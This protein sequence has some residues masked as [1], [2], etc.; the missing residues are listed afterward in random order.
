MGCDIHAHVEIKVKG[1]WLHYSVPSIRRNYDLFA[2]MAN[3]R[4]NEDN[5]I[6][7]LCIP[8]GLPDDISDITKHSAEDWGEDGHDHSWLSSEEMDVV[9]NWMMDKG[10]LKIWE[11]VFGYLEG[12]GFLYKDEWPDWIEDA[13]LVFWF[14]C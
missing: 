8:R 13:R 10:Y 2:Y 9:E 14:D 11:P 7:P 12:N 3:V 1:K 4:N 5:P 6:M